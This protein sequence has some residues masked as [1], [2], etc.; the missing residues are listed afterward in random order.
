MRAY[1]VSKMNGTHPRGVLVP[2][3]YN[4]MGNF[5]VKCVSTNGTSGSSLGFLASATSALTGSESGPTYTCRSVPP[6]SVNWKYQYSRPLT[7]FFAN[8]PRRL[9]TE[10]D[11]SEA[12][13]ASKSCAYAVCAERE[14]SVKRGIPLYVML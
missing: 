10:R 11:N 1:V 6:R 9:P 5:E 3:L 7:V 4:Y 2:K 12:S 8:E 13:V 14:R